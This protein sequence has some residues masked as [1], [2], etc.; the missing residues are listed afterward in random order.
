MYMVT[1]IYCWLR[2]LLRPSA[3]GSWVNIIKD[4]DYHSVT[5]FDSLHTSLVN[6][7][8][9]IWWFGNVILSLFSLLLLGW[10]KASPPPLRENCC[11]YLCIYVVIRHP[12]V[13]HAWTCMLT[14]PPYPIKA[15]SGKQAMA[16]S[17]QHQSRRDWDRQR[18]AA[19]ILEERWR[20]LDRLKE[21]RKQWREAETPE[22]IETRWSWVRQQ[23]GT[24]RE[25]ED[26][27]VTEARL[28]RMRE[29]ERTLHS[30]ETSEAR[31]EH[32]REYKRILCSE[33]WRLGKLDYRAYER[34]RAVS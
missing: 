33:A 27:Q 10:A 15:H 32:M 30:E 14:R 18:P 22:Q 25:L 6:Q 23:Q 19:K 4:I 13:C 34:S 20:R 26:Q 24:H 28:E 9:C 7:P 8:S 16:T 2:A 3:S 5:R 29:Y 12:R 11:T 17:V 31:Q 1:T 21:Y